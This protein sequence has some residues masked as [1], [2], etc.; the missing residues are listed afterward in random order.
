MI[1]TSKDVCGGIQAY[2]RRK[3]DRRFSSGK[4]RKIEKIAG[5]RAPKKLV[6]NE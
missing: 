6:K 2:E 3:L 5:N 1:K 4:A